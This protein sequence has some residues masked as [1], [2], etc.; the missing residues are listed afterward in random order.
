MLHDSKIFPMSES[1]FTS[2]LCD[3]NQISHLQVDPPDVKTLVS[4]LRN[5]D[6]SRA[7]HAYEDGLK[8]AN[9]PTLERNL[10]PLA[11]VENVRMRDD[12]TEADHAAWQAIGLQQVVE[13]KA[14]I[15][16]LG[17]GQ[18]TRLKC[19]TCKGEF[20]AGWPSHEPLY[21]IFVERV[22]RIRHL[23]A[24]STGFKVPVEDIRLPI[25]VMTSP[26][27]DGHTRAFFARNEYFG[28]PQSQIHIFM[29]CTLPCFSE[30]GKVLMESAFKVAESP[31]GNGGIFTAMRRYGIIDKLMASGVE[32]FQVMPVDNV[33]A[34]VADPVFS[35]FCVSAGADIGTKVV[36]KED[37]TE[38]VGLIAA[39][40]LSNGNVVYAPVEYS[41]L[42]KELAEKTD[43]ATGK[44]VFNAGNTCIHWF[45][46][47]TFKQLADDVE[48]N[49][50]SWIRYHFANKS[51]PIVDR[52]TGKTMTKE[53]LTK[54]GN[55]GVKLETFMFD[56]FPSL[57]LGKM[58]VMEVLRDEE[59]APIKNAFGCKHDSPETALAAI[60]ALHHSWLAKAGATVTC[61][62]GADPRI[63][64]SAMVS[65][66]GEGLES[67][68]GANLTTP[69]LILPK[70]GGEMDALIGKTVAQRAGHAVRVTP[71]VT[72]LY[73]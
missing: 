1:A 21:Q 46:L 71:T 3:I 15:V 31:D 19:P 69:L 61:P 62:E 51:I 20:E 27:T 40:R 24:K 29:Q 16:I 18:A 28:I 17:G 12:A 52:E 22:L 67:L 25:C 14:S 43:P 57:A 13:G 59:F 42:P 26:A 8:A 38:K 32:H 37:P 65:Y 41:E 5:I 33:A 64:I 72:I 30:D 66:S 56:A 53:A 63:E 54:L 34:R 60:T 48:H 39:E 11:G 49:P 73:L 9:A 35:G 55:T 70:E 23:A 50:S 44:L 47:S 58:A 6:V 10:M 45:R 7:V 4:Q 68:S 2:H 36:G